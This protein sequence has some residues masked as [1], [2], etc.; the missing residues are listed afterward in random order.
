[1]LEI[2]RKCF[3]LKTYFKVQMSIIANAKLD[4]NGTILQIFALEI[5]LTFLIQL[6]IFKVGML[7][8]VNAKVIINGILL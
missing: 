2:V 8:F 1:V 4:I 7:I 3:T 6:K 5:V